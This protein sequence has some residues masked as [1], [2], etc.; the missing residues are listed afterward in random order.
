MFFFLFCFR[1][2][3]LEILKLDFAEQNIKNIFDVFF[4]AKKY[5]RFEAVCIYR[6]SSYFYEMGN[7]KMA[8]HFYRKN[9]RRNSIEIKP[10]VK[11][12]TGLVIGHPSGIVIGTG[13]KIGNNF[14][15]YQGVTLGK[16][17]N[18]EGYP[19]LGDNVKMFAGSKAFGKI[20]IG[21]NVIIGANSV[22]T[23]SSGDDC[24]IAGI[25]G[26]VIK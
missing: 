14:S 13:T 10:P 8:Y 15:V 20:I 18:K 19:T 25:P 16:T 6:L 24:I 21:S 7:K 11:I 5:P 26:K 17:Y 3:L 2:K 22:V 9:F 23:K 1:K 12:G 4:L